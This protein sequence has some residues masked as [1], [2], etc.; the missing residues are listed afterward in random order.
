MKDECQAAVP[1]TIGGSGIGS[2]PITN[3]V[4]TSSLDAIL[5]E[6]MRHQTQSTGLTRS[7]DRSS[8]RNN[9]RLFPISTYTE[10]PSIA[11]SGGITG[12]Q[13]QLDQIK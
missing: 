2:G 8:R 10:M 4:S 6:T 5:D 12:S 11:S 13:T 1:S 7:S 3:H 9:S